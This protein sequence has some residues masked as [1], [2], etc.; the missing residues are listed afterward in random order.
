MRD[1]A[2]VAQAAIGAMAA[3]LRPHGARRQHGVVAGP[4][5]LAW[6]QGEAFTPED[7]CDAQPNGAAEGCRTLFAGFLYH[8]GELAAKLGIAPAAAAAMAD[9]ALAHAAWMKW[10]AD[11]VDHLYGPFALIAAESAACRLIA[12][13]SRDGAPPVY[14]HARRDRIALAT[15]PSAIFALGDVPRDLDDAR[16]ADALI[17]NFEDRERS[18]FAALRCLPLGHMLEATPETVVVRRRAASIEGRELRFAR[19]ADYVEAA[20]ELL[21]GAVANAMRAPQTPATTLSGGYD[22]GAVAVTALD[23][24]GGAPLTSFTAIPEPGWSGVAHG[25]GRMGD[26][27]DRV[28]ALAAMYPALDARFSDSAGQAQDR[29]LDALIALA[30][31]PPTALSNLTW[32]IDLDRLAR[33][34]G[35][36]VM[37]HGSSGNATL[38]FS[39]GARYP[40]LLR[41]GRWLTLARELRAAPHAHSRLA[42]TYALALRPLL[43]PAW[44]DAVARWRGQG[45]G[46]Y[47][48]WS[49]IAPDYAAEMEVE[50][51]FPRRGGRVEAAA[52]TDPRARMRAMADGAMREQGQAIRFAMPALTGV[53]ARDP[54]GDRK[55]VHYCMSLPPEQFLDRGE[56]RRL[57]RRMMRGRLPDAYFVHGRGRQGADWHLRITRELPRYR[58]GVERIADD[59][60]LARR[61]DIARLRRLLDT[62]PESVPA[63]FGDHP[64]YLLAMQGMGRA[65]AIARFVEWA[66]GRG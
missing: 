62:W 44:S 22:S 35:H 38:S 28:R 9:S 39:G 23:L 42:S 49:A 32:S 25:P 20:G 54:L 30:E 56:D 34:A 66:K 11:C 29:D 24:L 31:V 50:R 1:G 26:E 3:A 53:Q 65:L 64:D 58:T 43:P 36:R 61:F 16:I 12:L 2:P 63:G 33:D 27:S 10:Q 59:P 40:A 17:L 6:A 19:D 45:S 52:F 7:A 15:S 60:D 5:G 13:R 46:G 37:L 8:R 57:I 21:R 55:I 48:A 14:Y 4:I 41:Q 18:Y 47:A 51:R